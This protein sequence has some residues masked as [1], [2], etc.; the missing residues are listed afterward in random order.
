MQIVLA[1][2]C[3]FSS[4]LII[5]YITIPLG[6]DMYMEY[7]YKEKLESNNFETEKI[8]LTERD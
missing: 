6:I 8:V 5:I 3:I 2:L 1:M 4:A 7:R